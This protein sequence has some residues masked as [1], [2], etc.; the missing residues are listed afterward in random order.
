M[1]DVRMRP[2]RWIRW[3]LIVLAWTMFGLFFT[4][5]D[6]IR[7]SYY[8]NPFRLGRSLAVWLGSAYLWAVL[9]PFIIYFARRFSIQKNHWL[10]GV[11]IH[12]LLGAVF[13]LIELLGFVLISPLVRLPPLRP[14]FLSS[15]AA[16]F[17]IDFH[18]D[19]LTYWSIIGLIHVFD[20]YRK[21]QERE[22]KASQLQTQLVQAQL[23]ALK[24]QIHPHFL[25]NTLNAIVVL[26]RKNNNQAAV[27]MLTGLSELLRYSLDSMGRQEVSLRQELV[28]LERYL[29]IERMRFSDRMK[30]IMKIDQE[31]LDA[32]VP[33]LI[34]QPLVENAIRHGIGKRSSAGL[35]EI[36]ATHKNGKL[37]LQVRDDGS[38]L[39]PSPPDVD[40]GG[41]GLANTRARLEHLYGSEQVFILSNVN[42]GGVVATLMIPY[43]KLS[44]AGFEEQNHEQDSGVDRRR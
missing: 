10:R 42:G 26:V 20:Y 32:R 25:F 16:A 35:V 17:V 8:G 33:N 15:Y 4:S 39:S 34:L 2:G 43:Q 18:W 5:Q 3:L 6:Y 28:F 38:G 9:T 22:L 21:Y 27:D 23:S 30:V 13:S 37:Q 40:K 14:T 1:K 24:M 31:T 11:L 29:E 12:L 36:S 41:I 7:Q 19:I 44:A